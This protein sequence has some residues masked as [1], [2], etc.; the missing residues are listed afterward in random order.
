MADLS[1]KFPL[2]FT[3]GG[4]YASNTEVAEVVKQNFKNLLLTSPGERVMLPNFGVGVRN[5]LFEQNTDV[6]VQK[7]FERTNKQIK[8]YMPFIEIQ[9][10]SPQY[11]GNEL[12]IT[13]NYRILPL[14][15]ADTLSISI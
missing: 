5:Y 4:G 7:L 14:E 11:E 2:H 8:E 9:Q 1:P 6:A 3:D 12:F 15:Y 13:I 10:F